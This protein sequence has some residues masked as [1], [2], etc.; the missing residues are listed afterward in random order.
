ML[1]PTINDARGFQEVAAGKTG[2]AKG[3]ARVRGH[4]CFHRATALA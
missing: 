1:K 2:A 4:L 3:S